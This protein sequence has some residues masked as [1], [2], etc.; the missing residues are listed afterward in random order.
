MRVLLLFCVVLAGCSQAPKLVAPVAPVDPTVYVDFRVVPRAP[1]I[2]AYP[3]VR[4]H[5]WAPST[6]DRVFIT[7]KVANYPAQRPIAPPPPTP[8]A[9]LVA[10]TPVAQVVKAPVVFT[11]EVRF[12]FD[13]HNLD[14]TARQAIDALIQNVGQVLPGSEIVV[15]GFTDSVG[16]TP[17]NQQLSLR[18]A[19]SVR[20]A[21]ISHGATP[22]RI[23][24]SGKGMQSP[25]ETN[26]TP[27]GRAQNRRAAIK[28][29]AD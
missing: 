4:E 18:R 28:V 21:L 11:A 23:S 29:T 15:D 25:V 19:E 7:V 2:A 26:S 27:D 12:P 3:A 6:G 13:R 17:Y 20:Q 8:S 1:D 9:P 22:S 5:V 16:T 10:P 24:V 14:S